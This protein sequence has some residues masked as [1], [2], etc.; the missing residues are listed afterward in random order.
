MLNY[1]DNST[2]YWSLEQL[3]EVFSR[4]CARDGRDP[5]SVVAE[6]AGDE[7]DVLEFWLRARD[8]LRAGRVRMVFVS[9][10]IPRELRRVVEFLNGQMNPGEVIAI[11]V[12][13][14]LGADRTQDARPPR[15][16]GQTAEVDARKGR[17]APGDRRRWDE[18]SVFTE[19][20]DKRGE[21]ETHVAR[22]LYHWTLGRGWRPDFGTGKL[23]GSWI[24]VLVA[25]A[26]E[27]YPIALYTYGQVEL[28][29]Q[30]LKARPR[31]DDDRTR[32]ELLRHVN[33]RS[34]ACLSAGTRSRGGRRS[35]SACWRATPVHSSNSSACSSGSRHTRVEP[36]GRRATSA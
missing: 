6:V 13:Q 10:E 18:Q 26:R 1:A 32:L 31:F 17:R 34:P 28:Q 36:T 35:H 9:D 15:V 30:H 14:Y 8:N 33:E 4:Q 22:D 2:F 3:R 5:A 23:D 25:N 7:V 12:K 11:E 21:Q 29:F 20:R 24:A 16:I 19:L 27:H